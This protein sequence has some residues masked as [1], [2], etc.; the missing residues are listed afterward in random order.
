MTENIEYIINYSEGNL[1]KRKM[2]KF[3]R[4][5]QTNIEL[6]ENYL[7]YKQVN[8]YMRGKFDLEEVTSDP[9]LKETDQ[10]VSEAI[11]DYTLNP[12]KFIDIRKFVNDALVER[13]PEM[14]LK[15]EI[16]QINQEIEDQNINE[17]AK[18]I[19]TEFSEKNNSNKIKNAKTD[20]I[21]NYIK[22]SLDSEKDN[23]ELE[24]VH[25]KRSDL[26]KYTV[27]RIISLSAA[28]LIAGFVLIKT[29]IPSDNPEK[30]FASYYKPFNIESPVTREYN[31]DFS[32]Q[33][34]E[35]I[36]MYKQGKY[37]LAAPLFNA[38]VQKDTSNI[39]ASFYLGITQLELRNY[40][41]A[42]TQLSKS[43]SKPQEFT[44]EAQW[45]LGLSYLKTGE[46][47]KAIPY[48][49]ILSESEGFYQDQAKKLLR[50]LK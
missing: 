20:E 7:V 35:A 32:D 5:L 49:E 36:N 4:E 17:I 34:A 25:N 21:R 38:L 13:K 19:V 9:A 11:S 42:I 44:K 12:G 23:S 37:D 15:E 30:L 47:T 18:G 1:S 33:Y 8:E 26:Q 6:K 22:Q 43:I 28:V 40:E 29:L 27:I 41:Q 46:K 2:R 39:T 3:E 45:Y 31:S 16:T 48:F 50:R 14:N 24:I 10:L